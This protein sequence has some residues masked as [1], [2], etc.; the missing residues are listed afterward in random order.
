MDE[1]CK[2]K[3]HFKASLLKPFKVPSKIASPA[4]APSSEQAEI[5]QK[6]DKTKKK[7]KVS[8]KNESGSRWSGYDKYN[9]D[10]LPKD[11]FIHEPRGLPRD[12]GWQKKID[13]E[14]TENETWMG[15]EQGRK[16]YFNFLF[17]FRGRKY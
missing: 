6:S 17:V 11:N 12:D 16:L 15:R 8:H 5:S 10:S 3:P 7:S 2:N 14:N 1:N 9:Y 13:T 4:K